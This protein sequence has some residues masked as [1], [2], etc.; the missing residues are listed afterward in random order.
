MRPPPFSR[1][2][3]PT[4]H[5][6]SH[7]FLWATLRQH[8]QCENNSLNEVDLEN[9]PPIGVCRFPLHLQA[10]SA[11][12]LLRTGG[13]RPSSRCHWAKFRPASQ[14]RL[15]P[16]EITSRYSH[17]SYNL[18]Q[19][20]R[21]FCPRLRG[22]IREDKG[23]HGRFVPSSGLIGGPKRNT[24]WT[25]PKSYRGQHKLCAERKEI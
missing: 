14:S 3:G 25:P 9:P 10:R 13:T 17:L 1:V 11:P 19:F 18:V 23:G 5:K 12:G 22:K 21:F 7:S 16:R 8:W 15:L 4:S 2:A 24:A 20:C 6:L